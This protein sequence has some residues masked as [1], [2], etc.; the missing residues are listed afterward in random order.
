ML[1]TIEEL[2]A[3][4]KLSRETI[5]KMAQKGQIPAIKIGSQWRFDSEEI[6]I[7]LKTKSNRPVAAKEKESRRSASPR[8]KTSNKE[9]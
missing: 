5:Y 2:A 3:Q 6:E 8:Q 4:L 1:L 7:W 9:V